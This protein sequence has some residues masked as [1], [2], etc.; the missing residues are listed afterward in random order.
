VDAVATHRATLPFR[1]GVAAGQRLSLGPRRFRIRSAAD[2]DG[3]R[4]SLVCLVEEIAA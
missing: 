4:V 2:P 3:R 1:D